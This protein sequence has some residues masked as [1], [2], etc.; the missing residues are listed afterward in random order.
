M[1][2]KSLINRLVGSDPINN[3]EAGSVKAQHA[4]QRITY[5]KDIL[6][7]ELNGFSRLGNELKAWQKTYSLSPDKKWFGCRIARLDGY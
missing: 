7:I 6:S 2:F 5:H 4:E 1:I 3:K